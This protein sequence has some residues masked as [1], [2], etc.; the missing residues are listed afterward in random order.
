MLFALLMCYFYFPQF[1]F[2]FTFLFPELIRA[3]IFFFMA[4][5][6][7]SVQTSI[8]NDIG[9]YKPRNEF[10]YDSLTPNLR[11]NQE[12]NLVVSIFHGAVFPGA[13]YA[14][15]TLHLYVLI[16]FAS[17]ESIRKQFLD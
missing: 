13:L 14:G 3:Y 5:I 16:Q 12:S 7:K 8:V 1:D 2:P 11:I 4:L 15:T 6:S 9:S 10:T 17:C